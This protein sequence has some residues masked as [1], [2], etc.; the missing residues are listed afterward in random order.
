MFFG[1]HCFPYCAFPVTSSRSVSLQ[2]GLSVCLVC[3]SVQSVSQSS[4]SVQSVQSVSQCSQSVQS[5]S[6]V[7]QS[8]QSASQSSQSASRVSQSVQS[9]TPVSQSFSPVSE[10]VSQPKSFPFHFFLLSIHAN[11]ANPANSVGPSLCHLREL[12]ILP[13][14]G[15]PQRACRRVIGL[16]NP[17]AR[18]WARACKNQGLTL[19]GLPFC[20][21]KG[22]E[23]PNAHISNDFCWEFWVF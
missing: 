18:K 12:T 14:C 19:G 23:S 20:G 9:V 6:P 15:K 8:L 17:E 10:S 7:S 22:L 3:Q 11:P 4:Q 2:T 1:F 16:T 21:G 13:T 5:V